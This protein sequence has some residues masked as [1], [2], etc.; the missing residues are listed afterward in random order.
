MHTPLYFDNIGVWNPGWWDFGGR[1]I[2]DPHTTLLCPPPSAPLFPLNINRC[3]LTIQRTPSQLRPIH[4][5]AAR[6][7]L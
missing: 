3:F 4:N 1:S 7:R 5:H 6:V 2:L